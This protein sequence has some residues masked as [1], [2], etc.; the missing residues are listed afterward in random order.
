[1]PGA[2]AFPRTGRNITAQ[3]KCLL[4]RIVGIGER[5][6]RA[7]PAV[8]GQ[9]FAGNKRGVVACQPEDSLSYLFGLAE[10]PERMPILDDRRPALLRKTGPHHGRI[11]SAG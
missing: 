1:M 11:N 4:A 6:K 2:C 7:Q 10:S 9:V 5:G 3:R 8:D